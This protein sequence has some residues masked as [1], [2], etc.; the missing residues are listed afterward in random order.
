MVRSPAPAPRLPA[1]LSIN[2]KIEAI[3]KIERR[4][5]EIQE[6]DPNSVNDSSD[7]RI[8]V[9]EKRLESLLESVFGHNTIEYKRYEYEAA[10]LDRSGY[11]YGY[12]I[13]ISSI[14]KG[15]M[16][17]KTA[18]INHLLEIIS[19]FKEDIGD[20]GASPVGNAIRAFQGLDLHAEIQRAVGQLYKDGHYAN[21]IEDSVKALNGLVRLRSGE[22]TR[23]GSS[24]MEFVF[25]P[26]N[27]V[28]KFND[29][30]D[31]SDL[32]EQRGFMMLFSGAVAGLRNP[33]A[34]KIIKDDPESALEFIAFVSLLAKLVD[35]ATK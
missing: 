22:D 6:F 10:K 12:E 33:R 11:S 13:P 8:S 7:P 3:P 21:A 28:L 27:P 4:I 9:L 19:Q 29:L 30:A 26:R 1:N 35:R 25:N 15:L 32:D 2:Q 20:K 16:E 5:S 34:H 17:G 31:Q 23:D 18:I 24:L 14:R